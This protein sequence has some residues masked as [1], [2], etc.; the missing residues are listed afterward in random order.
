MKLGLVDEV[1]SARRSCSRPR[2]A[3]ALELAAGSSA[4]RAA[5][6]QAD[7][8]ARRPSRSRTTP[9][10]RALLFKKARAGDAQRRPTGT[11][12]RPSASSTCSSARQRRASRAAAAS[13]AKSFGEL[14]VSETR[15][16]P[17]R[18]LLRHH[19]PQE[20]QRGRRPERRSRA[21]SRALRMLGGGLMGGGIAYVT[22]SGR[23][24]VCACKDKDDAGVRPRPRVRA[25]H[26]RRAGEEEAASPRE[27]R[28]QCFAL[29]TGTHRLL[30]PQARGRRHRGRLRGPRPEAAGPA[31]RGGR[32]ARRLHLRVEHVVDPDRRRSPRPSK[33]PETVV[34]M[35]YFSPVHKMPLLEVIATYAPRP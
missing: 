28:D 22:M 25:R 8:G 3:R 17:H 1:V 29:L 11:T 26:P 20:G 35:H 4:A 21:R 2:C 12:R 13:E 24:L 33:R 15:P 5:R 32:H 23:H 6:A 19:R 18:D 7:A 27:E 16:P 31:R 10:G 30:G 9:L 34:G 14:V